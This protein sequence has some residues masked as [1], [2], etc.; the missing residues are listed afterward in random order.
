MISEFGFIQK[1]RKQIK[2]S[3][4]VKTGIGDDA[5]VLR[6][7]REDILFTTDMLIEGRHFRLN[8]ASLFE[9]G[10]K[11]VAVN[12]S[13]IAAMGGVPLHAV[14]A[15][16]LP[17]R[18]SAREAGAL[19]DGIRFMARKF[20]VNIVGGDTNA[21][22]KLIVS[23]A[24][25]GAVAGNK[26]ILRSGAKAGDCVWV[27]GSLGGSYPSGKHLNFT[28]RIAEARHLI[29]NYDVHAMMDISDGLA[30]DLFRMAGESRVGFD[31]DSDK[32]PLSS[33]K[34]T[35]KEA[36]NDGEDFELLFTLSLEDSLRLK[37]NRKVK[38]LSKFVEIGK[39]TQARQKVRLDG[40]LMKE[41]GFDHFS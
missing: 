19:Q 27:T 36:L 11:A 10:K 12:I 38:N 20:K 22:D 1:I 15:V 18:F 14:V 31:I 39:V 41:G 4:P 37:K 34:I 5:A 26:A 7:T 16:G 35:L 9:I 28:P 13:D 2:A 23:V 6:G 17:E 40:K 3:P 29:K 30:S 24:L 32:I 8:E 25:L 33:R 21:S